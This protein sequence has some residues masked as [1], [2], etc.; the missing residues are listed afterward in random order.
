MAMARNCFEATGRAVRA[1][2]DGIARPREETKPRTGSHQFVHSN[3]EE[4][5]DHFNVRCSFLC[6]NQLH[7]GKTELED[8]LSLRSLHAK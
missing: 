1:W 3:H 2:L 7:R 5:F 8:K 6:T 4:E